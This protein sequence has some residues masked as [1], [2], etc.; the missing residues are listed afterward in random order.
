MIRPPRA[1]RP[2]R[3]QQL[4][5]AARRPP[6]RPA[7]RSS[8]AVPFAQTGPA[9]IADH[10]D[11]WNGSPD[12]DRRDQRGGWRQ[13]PAA[14]ARGHRHRHAD[15]RRRPDVVPD[16][17]RQEGRRHRLAVRRSPT[18]RRSTSPLRRASRTS[19]AARR[20]R[21]SRPPRRT[22]T[23]T[24]TSSRTRPRPTTAPASSSRSTSSSR[25]AAGRRRTTRS[26]SW[27]ATPS[28]TS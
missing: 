25:R 18:S 16:A 7:S 8:S 11:C 28:T 23:S 3:R 24:G 21:R 5:P 2:T 12:G 17:G 6:P 20:R 22:R 9:G 27:S 13:R 4:P 26:T 19:P 14:E 10:K 1:A 15:A